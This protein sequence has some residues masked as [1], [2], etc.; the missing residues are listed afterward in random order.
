MSCTRGGT[1]AIIAGGGT[2]GHVYPAIALAD[3]LAARGHD[4]TTLRF[5]GAQRGLEARAVPA[6]GYGID[7]LGTRGLQRSMTLKN[8]V[9]NATLPFVLARAVRRAIGILRRLRPKVLVSVGGYASV[10]GVLAAKACRVPMVVHEQN[11]IPGLA[12]RAAVALGARAAV[13]LPGTALRGAVI[14]GNPVRAAVAQVRHEPDEGHAEIA[15]FG[16]SLG[17]AV[18]NDAALDLYDRWRARDD[19]SIHHIAGPRNFA[20]T[21]SRLAA[22][23]KPDDALRYELVEYEQEMERLYARS[24]LA[25]CRAGAVTVAE[26]AA[27]GVPS[28]LVPWPGAA[29]DHQTGNAQAMAGAGAAVVIRDDECSGARLAGVAGDLLADAGRLARM[30]A[31]AQSV[32]RPDAADRLAD[33]VEEV[34]G[35]TA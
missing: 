17:S 9:R 23:R 6:A 12:N 5:M 15:I 21:R 10:P 19:V 1:F 3:A 33:L 2:G 26:L 4:R 30:S 7:L 13:S 16:G 34:A 28:V 24:T 14:T 31:A 29:E 11:A 22:L 8:L 27:A 32:G 20:A 25:V 35:A 18:L